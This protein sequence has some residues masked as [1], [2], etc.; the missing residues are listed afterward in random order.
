MFGVAT[1]FRKEQ[2]NSLSI[3]MEG[4]LHGCPLFEQVAVIREVDLH[5]KWAPFCTSS[6]TIKDLDKLDTVGW[7]CLGLPQFGLARDGCFRAVGCDNM[8]EDGHIIVV[9]QGLQDRPAGVPYA[10]PSLLVDGLD[11]PDPPTRLGSGR[12]TI[13]FFHAGVHVLSPTSM[14][15][16]LVTNVNP[17]V[18][19]L[20]QS[21]IDF[22]M[23]KVCGVVM[24]TLQGAAKKAAL[25]PVK[26]AHARRIRQQESFYKEWLLPK[27]KAYCSTVHWDMPEVAALNLT[28]LQLDEEF[29]YLESRRDDYRQAPSLVREGSEHQYFS[30]R[31]APDQF[32]HS[33]DDESADMSSVSGGTAT[34]FFSKNPLISY[35]KEIELKTEAR[36]DRKVELS[37]Q[38][39][40]HRLR[41]KAFKEAEMARLDELKKFKEQR[42][43]CMRASV[44][45]LPSIRV[46]TLSDTPPVKSSPMIH[47]WHTQ[48]RKIQVGLIIILAVIM[49]TLLYAGELLGLHETLASNDHDWLVAIAMDIG[50]LVYLMACAATHFIFCELALVYAFDAL[51]IGMKTG[52]ETKKFYDGTVRILVACASA[53]FI[54]F[55]IGQ[56]ASF[57]ILR[58]VVWYTMMATGNA[59][60][61]VTSVTLPELPYSNYIPSLVVTIPLRFMSWM[62]ESSAFIISTMASVVSFFARLLQWIVFRSNSVG[63]FVSCLV[64]K[65]I[66]IIPS[67][68]SGWDNYLD[69]VKQVFENGEI[70]PS[71][72]AG[73]IDTSRDLLAYTAVFLL[74]I[75]ILFTASAK[76]EQRQFNDSVDFMD[77]IDFDQL[78]PASEK[79]SFGST[80]GSERKIPRMP[81]VDELTVQVHDMDTIPI[82]GEAAQTTKKKRR[83]VP[84]LRLR[85]KNK[86]PEEMLVSSTP[87]ANS[88]WT[89]KAK[90]Y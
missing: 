6:L 24:A 40:A 49:F 18:P 35:L 87:A 65:V 64:A 46:T 89:L 20:P 52:R 41:P 37:R 33:A 42:M 19:F 5:Y 2:D 27:F 1:Y 82:T 3:K 10:E 83:L 79:M 59:I 74:S 31:S 13:N 56:A 29:N 61:I 9:G 55:G 14:R 45:K 88:S 90:S 38:R 17:N 71:W 58:N 25:S 4:E 8:M 34:N 21:L 39:M 36:K 43:N 15:S 11:I 78:A 54:A 60:E 53:G 70:E 26:N 73:A 81:S 75:L 32:M 68:L 16:T 63:G 50:T 47:K 44:T 69:H 48:S 85:R 28:D 77:S 7:F 23:R 84:K 66:S 67:P 76:A 12:M 86:P 57:V 80:R 62:F 30:S 72:R 22:M 51:E